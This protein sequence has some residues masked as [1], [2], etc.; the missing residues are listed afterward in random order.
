MVFYWQKKA[1]ELGQPYCQNYIGYSYNFGEHQEV[2]PKLALHWF[3]SAAKQNISSA[4]NNLGNC[5]LYGQSSLKANPKKAFY[6]FNKAAKQGNKFAMLNL[7]LLYISGKGTDKIDYDAGI[8]WLE[9][10]ANKKLGRALD[11]LGDLYKYGKGVN[12]N[13]EKLFT[14]I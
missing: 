9:S 13:Q 3:N 4:Q 2:N 12:I 1:A 10:A 7:V 6:W 8:Y 5:F 11:N 14:I